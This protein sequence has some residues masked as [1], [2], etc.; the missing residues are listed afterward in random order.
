MNVKIVKKNGYV[1][2]NGV[3][4]DEGSIVDF[5]DALALKLI[6]HGF[7]VPAREAAKERAVRVPKEKASKSITTEA[8]FGESR[9]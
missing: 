1:D 2:R 8:F 9:E 5:P 6:K 7:V 4:H 3:M